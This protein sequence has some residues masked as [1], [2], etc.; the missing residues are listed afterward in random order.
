MHQYG[1]ATGSFYQCS[2][3]RS[4]AGTDDQIALLTLLV[5]ARSRVT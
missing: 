4:I 5:S 3:R 2:D 1:E